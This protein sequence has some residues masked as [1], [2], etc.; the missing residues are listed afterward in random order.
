MNAPGQ[1]RGRGRLA[2]PDL[3]PVDEL[4]AAIWRLALLA[5]LVGG[6]CAAAGFYLAMWWWLP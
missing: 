1:P 5:G 2:S 3:P 4:R 6:W